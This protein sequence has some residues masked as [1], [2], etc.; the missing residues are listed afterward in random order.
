MRIL[1]HVPL[2]EHRMSAGEELSWM[3]T[4]KLPKIIGTWASADFDV[5]I[6]PNGKVE[7]AVFVAGS[8]LLRNA[9]KNLQ[10]MSFTEALP[11]GST[12]YL[13]RRGVLSC[14]SACSFVFYPPSVAVSRFD[15][16]TSAK[17]HESSSTS[18]A[19]ASAPDGVFQVGGSITPPR[20]VYAPQPV[21]SEKARNAHYEGVCTLR[22]I[23]EKDGRP[24][25][26]RLV[27]GIG[28]GLDEN[29]IEAVKS[30]KF[31]PAMKDGQP[32]RVVIAI[33]VNFH[34]YQRSEKTN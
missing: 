33:E 5:L 23:V 13:R 9:D 17:E 12:A 27:K 15:Q 7:N 24:S 19:G 22:L 14:D 16:A 11:R 25:N 26:I 1:A 3:R 10:E 18:P 28:M 20:T 34:L 31:E 2:P 29:A 32:V 6:A 4:T 8:E 30:W 21:Y